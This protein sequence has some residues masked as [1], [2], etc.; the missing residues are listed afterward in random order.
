M[1]IPICRCTGKPVGDPSNPLTACDCPD[2]GQVYQGVG[3]GR[4]SASATLRHLTPDE[5]LRF[6]A[7]A[8][9][10]DFTRLERKVCAQYGAQMEINLIRARGP[11][12]FNR[13]RKLPPELPAPIK[14][15]LGHS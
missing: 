8:D 9:S 14:R 6:R 3:A 11:V 2:S 4:Y 10:L 15:L 7:M 5:E 12:N 1:S 13:R